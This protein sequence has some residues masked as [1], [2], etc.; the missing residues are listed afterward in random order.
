TP[1]TPSSAVTPRTVP[2]APTGVSAT[3]G[4]GSADVSWTTPA[5]DGGSAI[6]GYTVL[7]S[8]GGLTASAGPGATSATVSGL[9][10][11]TAYTFTVTAPNVAGDGAASAPS[12]AVTPSTIPGAPTGVGAVPGD[13]SATVS[14]TAPASDGGS[15][16]TGYTITSS[17]GQT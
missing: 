17:G 8:P 13:G 16:I 6:T 4:N 10:N 14:W 12:S 15:A 5:S 2:D 7:S 9:T 11:G 1:S 3:P